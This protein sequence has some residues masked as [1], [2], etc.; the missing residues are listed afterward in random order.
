MSNNIKEFESN[1]SQL[2]A[3]V[4]QLEQP[5][6]QNLAS[7]LNCYQKGLEKAKACDLAL[8]ETD[9]KIQ[10]LNVTSQKQESLT[11]LDEPVDRT[12]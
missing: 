9:Q 11:S 1:L 5:E 4:K 3:C 10:K 2:E 6:Q 7:L 8:K 12:S